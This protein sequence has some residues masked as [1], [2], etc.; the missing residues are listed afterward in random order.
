MAQKPNK[1]DNIRYLIITPIDEM[2]DEGSVIFAGDTE[3]ARTE[4]VIQ[5]TRVRNILQ[6]YSQSLTPDDNDTLVKCLKGYLAERKQ[7]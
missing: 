7:L 3:R 6:R 5:F 4:N 2:L 1:E